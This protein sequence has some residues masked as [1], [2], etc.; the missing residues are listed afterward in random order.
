[1]APLVGQR[2]RDLVSSIDS[3]YSLDS[4]AEEQILQMA[5][6]FVDK[7]TSQ[8]IRLAKHRGSNT[9]EVQDI[10]MIL[11]KQYGIVVP[12]MGAPTPKFTKGSGRVVAATGLKR[13]ASSS[14]LEGGSSR[15]VPSLNTSAA[16]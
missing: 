8:A 9:L 13:K 1:M 14:S 12:G 3:S 10:Q 5:D 7:V 6:D 16:V 11:A 2:L 4:R 15:K